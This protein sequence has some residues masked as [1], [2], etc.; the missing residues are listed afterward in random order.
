MVGPIGT[1]WDISRAK[2]LEYVPTV[3]LASGA[4]RPCDVV[5]G[6]LF[7]T[8]AATFDEAGGFDERYSPC[9]FEEV[10]YCT[11]ARLALGMEC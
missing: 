8:R 4:L 6:F 7:A 3:R 11:T 2:H 1:R 5:S 9:G 10:D